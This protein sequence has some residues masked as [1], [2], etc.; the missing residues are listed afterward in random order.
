MK[1][2]QWNKILVVLATVALGRGQLEKALTLV[3]T[4]AAITGLQQYFRSGCVFILYSSVRA[5]YG[6]LT[7][8]LPSYKYLQRHLAAT[9]E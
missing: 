5:N 2:L 3:E 6:E 1:Q 9:V 8:S 4:T 7:V